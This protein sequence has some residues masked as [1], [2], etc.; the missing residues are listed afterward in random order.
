MPRLPLSLLLL[1]AVLAF[2]SRAQTDVDAPPPAAYVVPI[3]GSLNAGHMALFQRAVGLA[4]GTDALLILALDTPGGSIAR[5]TAF[6]ESIEREIDDGLRVVAWVEDQ[7]LSAGT[8]IAITAESLYMRNRSTIGSATAIQIGP[9]GVKAV[10]E[11]MASAY[12]AWVRGWAEDHGR[13]PLLAQAMIDMDTEV[14]RVKIDGVEKLISGDTW[15]DLVARGEAPE[16]IGIEVR[17][18]QLLALT[19]REAIDYG[20]ADAL[21]ETVE[22]VMAKEGFAG[23]TFESLDFSRAE[24]W[25]AKLWEMRLLLLFLGLFFGYVELKMPGFGIPGVLSL[26]CFVVMFAGQYLVG[27]ADIPHIVLAAL[28]VVLVAGEL[29][30]FPGMIFPGVIGAL[31]LI[32][33]LLLSQ[34]GPGVSLSNAWHR[35][36]LFDATFQ[37]AAT[38]ALALLAIWLV[39]RFLPDTPILGRMV[40]AGG[41]GASTGSGADAMPETRDDSRL[42]R[43]LPGALGT[44]TTALRPVGKVTLDGDPSGLDHEARAESGVLEHGV[45]VEVVEVAAG[46]LLVRAADPAGAPIVEP[47]S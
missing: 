16:L 25:L 27:L 18:D 28:G 20:F 31:C 44:T 10:E 43:A 33:G 24:V 47:G 30:L 5:M 4:E 19:G 1:I 23:M 12:R 15:D 3:H 40:L 21:A 32:A 46:R 7:A 37:M 22:E 17:G 36:L 13:D 45:R 38:A 2:A 9:T 34:V 35:D 26:L 8:W 39:S 41:T 14:R 42:E 29:F 6:A 11:K